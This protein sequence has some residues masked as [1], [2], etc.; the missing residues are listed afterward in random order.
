MGKAGW[1]KQWCQ[2]DDVV[3]TWEKARIGEEASCAAGYSYTPS[4]VLPV[5]SIAPVWRSFTWKQE[6]KNSTEAWLELQ[7]WEIEIKFFFMDG[8]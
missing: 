3:L 1:P 7:N 6:G 8:T 4:L 5:N 2:F